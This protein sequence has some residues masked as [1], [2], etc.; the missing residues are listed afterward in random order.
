MAFAIVPVVVMV[1]GILI[2]T[3][4]SKPIPQRAGEWMFVCGL[5]VTC[6]VAAKYTLRLG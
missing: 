5:L 4:S 6:F 3:L 2:W 1:L